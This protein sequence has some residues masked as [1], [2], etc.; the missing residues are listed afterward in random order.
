MEMICS[1]FSHSGLPPSLML[2][3]QICFENADPLSRTL[4]SLREVLL[5]LKAQELACYSFMNSG[6]KHETSVSE[7]KDLLLPA[8][9]AVWASCAYQSP[10]PPSLMVGRCRR[11]WVDAVNVVGLDRSWGTPSLMNSSILQQAAGR[12]VQP[13][14]CRRRYLYYT[15]GFVY[16]VLEEDTLSLSDKAICYADI[17][18]KN[19]E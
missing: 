3:T 7:T 5:Y 8:Q 16:S 18:E 11:A 4:K 14:P 19:S 6:W 13:L 17:H 9:Q 12:P 15:R 2:S 1:F 10:C